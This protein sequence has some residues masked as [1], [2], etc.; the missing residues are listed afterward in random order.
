M[1]AA[2]QSELPWKEIKKLGDLQEKLGVSIDDMLGIVDKALHREPYTKEEICKILS[3][4][5]D[6]LANTSLS[7][8]TLH[9]QYFYCTL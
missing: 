6:D 3:V 2:T 8:N 7:A 1:I 4:Q 5:P 9:G